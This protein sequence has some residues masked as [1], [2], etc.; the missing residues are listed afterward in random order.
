MRSPKKQK[1][2]PKSWAVL[3]G[4]TFQMGVSL[5]FASLAG[6]ALDARWESGKTMTLSLLILI[7]AVNIYGLIKFLNRYN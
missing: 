4:L 5:Y 3:T 2:R 1:K 7:L 6:K